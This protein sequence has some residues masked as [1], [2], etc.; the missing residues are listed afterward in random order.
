MTKIDFIENLSEKLH[1]P[2][3]QIV[4]VVE[5]VFDIYQRDPSTRG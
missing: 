4:K 5:S 3:R 1:L 2:K